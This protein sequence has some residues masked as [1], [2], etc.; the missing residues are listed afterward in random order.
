MDILIV[1]HSGKRISVFLRPPCSALF[2]P[3]VHIYKGACMLLLENLMVLSLSG[4]AYLKAVQVL[5]E[6]I[7]PKLHPY[8][9]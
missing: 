1:L 3:Q 4:F 5:A 2:L 6:P 7:R 9:I 8:Y